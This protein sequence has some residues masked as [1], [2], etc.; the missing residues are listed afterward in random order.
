MPEPGKMDGLSLFAGTD[1]FFSSDVG[2]TGWSQKP[3]ERQITAAS[4]AA[5][6]EWHGRGFD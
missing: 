1:S 6:D 5:G 3:K 4:R 2:E